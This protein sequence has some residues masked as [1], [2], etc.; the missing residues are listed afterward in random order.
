[1]KISVTLRKKQNTENS[2]SLYL[3]IIR[4]NFKRHRKFL[5]LVL[6]G[7]RIQD[8]ITLR[9]A[10]EIRLKTLAD[11]QRDIHNLTI[12]S[13]VTLGELIKKVS[14]NEKAKSTTDTYKALQSH[15]NRFDKNYSVK[16]ITSVTIDYLESF[17]EYL[18]TKD[19]KN[20]SINSY[21]TKLKACFNY[22]AKKKY[23]S[24]NVARDLEFMKSEKSEKE[25][26]TIPELKRLESIEPKSEVLRAFLLACY[27]GL[28]ISDLRKLK[29][30]DIGNGKIKVKMQKTND[31]VYIPLTN[32]AKE[33]IN[34]KI[35]NHTGLVFK[36]P[37]QSTINIH[38]SKIFLQNE[39]LKDKVS[40]HI[41]RHSFATIGL[42]IGIPIEVISKVLGH[43]KLST[44]Q[45]YAKIVNEKINNE[46]EKFNKI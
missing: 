10:E 36:L 28:R 12:E 15:L 23:I 39:I 37:V 19:L 24:N 38:L 43:T 14:E 27:T 1:M 18:K 17:K 7:N 33:L 6:T 32:K 4:P 34:S 21:L 42:T 20:S 11:L 44:T 2:T 29:Y 3:D 13:R 31:F 5:G 26:L 46:M 45:I 35:L 41:S 25:F 40:F 30:N 9:T 16:K 8:R 22:A